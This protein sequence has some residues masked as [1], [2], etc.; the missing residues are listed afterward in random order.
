MEKRLL[1]KYLHGRAGTKLVNGISVPFEPY[2]GLYALEQ[3]SQA[4]GDEYNMV[5][6]HQQRVELEYLMS[7]IDEGVFK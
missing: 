7:L 1:V 3:I 4:Q 5:L 6:Y 2:H